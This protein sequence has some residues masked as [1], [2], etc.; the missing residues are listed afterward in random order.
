MKIMND[1]SEK[2]KYIQSTKEWL[3]QYFDTNVTK[4]QELLK[5]ELATSFLL[6][7]PIF[8]QTFFSNFCKKENIEKFSKNYEKFFSYE[9]I[10]QHFYLRYQNNDHYRNLTHQSRYPKFEQIL[11]KPQN[12]ITEREKLLFITFVVYRYRN[13]IFHGNKG[14]K[15]WSQFKQQ[16]AYCLEFMT[17][18]LNKKKLNN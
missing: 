15:S 16:I 6:I 12:Y 13:N 18:M 2:Y 10:F 4:I 7:W 17:S 5:D 14:I 11:H 3:A 8:E 9:E 1:I